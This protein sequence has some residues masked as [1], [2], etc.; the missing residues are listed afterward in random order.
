MSKNT[1]I[2]SIRGMNDWSGDASARLYHIEQNAIQI[3]SQAN[4]SKVILPV[5]EKTELFAR[6]VGNETDIVEKEMYSFS[7]RNEQLLSLRPE[8]TAGLVRA[9]IQNGWWQQG[10]VLRYQYSGAMFRR[11]RP[12]KGRY[13]QF[14]QFGAEVF[15][16]NEAIIDS[17]LIQLSYQWFTKLGLKD[18]IELHINSIGK[19]ADRQQ[20]R[21]ALIAYLQPFKE[22]LDEDSQRRLNTNPLR[23]L[24]SKIESTQKILQDAPRLQDFLCTQSQEHFSQVLKCLQ[25]LGIKYHINPKL[26][27]GLDYYNDT[28][29]EW[30]TDKL[31]SQSAVC[32]GGRYDGLVAE[33]GG[34]PCPAF[35]FAAGL[36]R[37]E[38]LLETIADKRKENVVDIYIVCQNAQLSAMALSLAAQTRALLPHSQVLCDSQLGSFKSQFKRADKSGAQLALIVA[39]EE[40]SKQAVIIKP[41]REERQQKTVLLKDIDTVLPTFFKQTE[42]KHAT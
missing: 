27:R 38:A 7:D 3:F 6:A 17:E 18:C 34:K 21:Q 39:E 15:G 19:L 31:G 16:G 22:Q 41:L 24:D 37:I 5:L 33:L 26:V 11:E 13:R 14:T 29:F 10:Q 28:V 8:G 25:E 12:Q 40:S 32:G 20:Y 42:I 2:Q 1:S 23:I 4:Y 30:V 9:V 36:E 35:G